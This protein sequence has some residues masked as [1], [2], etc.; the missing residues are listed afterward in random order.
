MK[1]FFISAL[2]ILFLSFISCK[3]K[4]K[5][6]EVEKEVIVYQ[7]P[8]HKWKRITSF[9][10]SY[11]SKILNTKKLTNGKVLFFSDYYYVQYDSVTNS[12]I[13]A[14]QAY[15]S[16]RQKRSLIT[17]SFF[18][19]CGDNS[20][21]LYPTI[22]FGS[23][24]YQAT[25]RFVPLSYYDPKFTYLYF[26]NNSFGTDIIGCNNKFLIPYYYDNFIG[27]SA[28]YL[29]FKTKYIQTSGSY[30]NYA[31]AIDTFKIF[32]DTINIFGNYPIK[33]IGKNLFFTMFNGKNYILNDNLDTTFI[34]NYHYYGMFYYNNLQ[35][36]IV[37]SFGT[38]YFMSTNNDGYSWQI[39][40]GNINPNYQTLRFSV[41]N[42]KI[43]AY[44]FANQIWE[45]QLNSN[46]LTAKELSN[47]GLENCLITSVE[48][49]NNRVFISTNNGVFERP[50][51]EFIDYK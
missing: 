51:T 11:S 6:V 44:S 30:P 21:N 13:N 20:V 5:I 47:D 32:K 2:L 27:P 37:N 33:N 28:K 42:G 36:A 8:Q 22:R 26:K 31:I 46:S 34:N 43:I 23:G 48:C 24:N 38:V 15:S 7:D 40:A 9:D 50:F 25:D 17:D 29:A 35:Y 45:I 1:Y 16:E 49:S 4:E 39:I 10:A 18:V 41:F 12:F 19:R 14:E 3:K